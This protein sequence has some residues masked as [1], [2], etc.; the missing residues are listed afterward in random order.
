MILRQEFLNTNVCMNS[1]F[2]LDGTI[3]ESS[4]SKIFH[5]PPHLLHIRTTKISTPIKKKPDW[6]LFYCYFE[7]IIFIN[8][9]FIVVHHHQSPRPKPVCARRNVQNVIKQQATTVRGAVGSSP[10]ASLCT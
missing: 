1:V 2:I 10:F 4:N 8:V 9:C 5:L 6:I 7:Y 3:V